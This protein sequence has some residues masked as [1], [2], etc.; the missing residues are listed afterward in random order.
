[1]TVT[2]NDFRT[3]LP[4]VE[5]EMA[6]AMAWII[7]S[8]LMSV[9]EFA[10]PGA[11]R[12]TWSPGARAVTGTVAW[13]RAYRRAAELGGVQVPVTVLMQCWA[14]RVLVLR[15]CVGRLIDTPSR[16]MYNSCTAWL[17]CDCDIQGST[18]GRH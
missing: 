16:G 4:R 2:P 8:R 12:H 5:K 1:M 3:V 18:H 13:W 14:N 9:N 6:C 15:S 17:L 11:C 10:A 7:P